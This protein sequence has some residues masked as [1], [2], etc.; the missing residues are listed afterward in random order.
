LIQILFLYNLKNFYA[1]QTTCFCT[2]PGPSSGL[3]YEYFTFHALM[4]AD[5]LTLTLQPF[6]VLGH[7][8]YLKV[9]FNGRYID[10]LSLTYAT[11]KGKSLK[12][13]L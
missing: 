7:L 12:V 4:C 3:F 8:N 9:F 1:P 5:I 10:Y 11:N 13:T 6:M 2:F